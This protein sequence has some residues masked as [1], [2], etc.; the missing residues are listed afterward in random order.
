PVQIEPG[1]Y[2][3]HVNLDMRLIDK[4]LGKKVDLLHQFRRR[5]SVE[6]GCLGKPDLHQEPRKE[7]L[8]ELVFD[9]LRTTQQAARGHRSYRK[10]AGAFLALVNVKATENGYE[11]DRIFRDLVGEATLACCQVHTAAAR[12]KRPHEGQRQR[13]WSR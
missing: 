1:R 5:K 2:I 8:A 3:D 13:S 11:I 9:T 7:V 10:G 4:L 12:P 6:V